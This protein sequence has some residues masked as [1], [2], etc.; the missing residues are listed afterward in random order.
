MGKGVLSLMRSH[1]RSVLA[2]CT[3]GDQAEL[4]GRLAAL[5]GLNGEAAR[6]GNAGAAA[7]AS[8]GAGAAAAA[9]AARQAWPGRLRCDFW[10]WQERAEGTVLLSVDPAQPSCVAVGMATSIWATVA[11]GGATPPTVRQIPLAFVYHPCTDAMTLV[12]DGQPHAAALP[13]PD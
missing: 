6:W 3:P 12:A 7:D 9:A 4:Y 2:A 5:F 11:K 10:V 8:A 13:R 1:L